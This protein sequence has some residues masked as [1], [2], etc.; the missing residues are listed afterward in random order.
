MAFILDGM[1]GRDAIQLN[2]EPANRRA[3]IPP[4]FPKMKKQLAII[5]KG[6]KNPAL[7][8]YALGKNLPKLQELYKTRMEANAKR[9]KEAGAAYLV[10][11]A[12]EK[13]DLIGAF[14]YGVCLAEG[15][16]TAD[17]VPRLPYPNWPPSFEP[18]QRAVASLR[19][20][21]VWYIP[22]SMSTTFVRGAKGTPVGGAQSASFRKH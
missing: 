1:V 12:A 18:K 3:R 17:D 15:V 11:A 4:D 7:L 16:G 21:H 2:R 14:N 10:K 13:G 22:A 6:A 5:V 9:E 20:T 19:R 8:V